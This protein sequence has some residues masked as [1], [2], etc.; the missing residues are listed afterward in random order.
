VIG[1]SRQ[2]YD[3]L[4]SGCGLS[5]QLLVMSAAG[6]SG[7]GYGKLLAFDNDGH[8]LGPFCDDGQA[9]AFFG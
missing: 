7:D 1:E 4:V 3:D 9:L 8:L 6:I 2:R 5:V